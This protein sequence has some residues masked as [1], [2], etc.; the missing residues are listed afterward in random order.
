MS[1]KLLILL[2]S[3]FACDISIYSQNKYDVLLGKPASTIESHM[4]KRDIKFKFDSLTQIFFHF[5]FKSKY[6][7]SFFIYKDSIVAVQVLKDLTIYGKGSSFHKFISDSR[8]IEKFESYFSETYNR[9]P[10]YESAQLT[11][12]NLYESFGTTVGVSASPT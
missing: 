9:L 2:I 5:E 12:R 4:L 3:V 7:Y 11:F 10:N 6:S 8:L 1:K